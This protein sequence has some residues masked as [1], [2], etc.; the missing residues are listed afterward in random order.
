MPRNS[1]AVFVG[2]YTTSYWARSFNIN[3]VGY[4][5]NYVIAI[6][7]SK[8]LI[9]TP[10]G[11]RIGHESGIA[12]RFGRSFSVEIWRGFTVSFGA[13]LLGG[14]IVTPR[15]VIGLSSV[16]NPIGIEAEREAEVE[17][18]DIA[19]L[20]YL[21]SELARS[22]TALPFLEVFYRLHHRSGASQFWGNVAAGHN[23]SGVGFRIW[24]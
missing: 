10:W 12:I 19:R 24:Y 15:L 22:L 1:L 16:S 23:A 20:V 17:N 7:S 21:G 18:G 3:A 13:E 14:S 11:L 5:P 9:A 6:I 4:E 8:D 2:V